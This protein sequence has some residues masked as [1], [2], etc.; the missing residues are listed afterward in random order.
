[1]AHVIGPYVV[2]VVY[3]YSNSRD[4]VIHPTLISRIIVKAGIPDIF[5][6]KKI[7]NEKIPVI[8]K[9]AMGLNC[10]VENFTFAKHNLRA[11]I[12]AFKVFRTG[13][14]QDVPQQL[15]TF[16]EALESPK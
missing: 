12:P 13:I 2:Y 3:A 9:I 6:I 16:K 1:M 14:I 10:L 7:G 15:E 4:N 8:V 5:E 11:F